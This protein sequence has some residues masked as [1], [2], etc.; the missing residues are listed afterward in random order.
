L[1]RPATVNFCETD[2]D[3]HTLDISREGLAL[4]TGAILDSD[5]TIRVIF[6]PEGN[7]HNVIE[8]T[9]KVVRTEGDTVAVKFTHLDE[10]SLQRLQSWLVDRSCSPTP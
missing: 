10:Q 3:A 5:Q 8:V 4:R 1:S 9:G 6:D 2:A 7:N